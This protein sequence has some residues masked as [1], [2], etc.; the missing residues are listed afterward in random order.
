MPRSPSTTSRNVSRDQLG[1]IDLNEPVNRVR[2]GI[3]TI[4]PDG[5]A[6]SGGGARHD[7]RPRA[8][9]ADE[10]AVRRRLQLA[11]GLVR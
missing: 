1:V 6:D 5:D 4:D 2:P 9:G 10:P 11:A 3:D 8:A 7:V